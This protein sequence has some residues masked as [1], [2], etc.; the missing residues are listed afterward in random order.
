MNARTARKLRTQVRIAVEK[1]PEIDPAKLWQQVTKD[2]L[3]TPRKEREDFS[4][5]E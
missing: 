1:H 4:I 2:Y 3:A 5:F